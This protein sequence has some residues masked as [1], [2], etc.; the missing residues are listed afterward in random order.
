MIV[1]ICESRGFEG[2]GNVVYVSHRLGEMQVFAPSSLKP[3]QTHSLEGDS[4]DRG[5]KVRL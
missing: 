2:Q 5:I 4:D 3:F 1:S